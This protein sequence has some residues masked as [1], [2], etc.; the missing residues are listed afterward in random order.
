MSEF[1]DR[2][3]HN[4]VTAAGHPSRAYDMLVELEAGMKSKIIDFPER[5]Q[6]LDGMVEMWALVSNMRNDIAQE[7]GYEEGK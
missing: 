2:I 7:Y 4:V 3:R 5:G 1:R 6:F